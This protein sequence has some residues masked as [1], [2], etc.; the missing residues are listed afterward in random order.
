MLIIFEVVLVRHD[1]KEKII[2]GNLPDRTVAQYCCFALESVVIMPFCMCD[3]AVVENVVIFLVAKILGHL[4][5]L[6]L[7]SYYHGSHWHFYYE[8]LPLLVFFSSFSFDSCCLTM[9]NSWAIL[10]QTTMLAQ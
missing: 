3:I 8:F 10:L 4:F 1:V 6:I 2:N 5:P 7:E 9:L